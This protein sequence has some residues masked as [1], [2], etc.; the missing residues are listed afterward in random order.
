[1]VTVVVPVPVN[2]EVLA[3]SAGRLEGF[4]AT[5]TEYWNWATEAEE[6]WPVV[7]SQPTIRQVPWTPWLVRYVTVAWPCRLVV[8]P[9]ACGWPVAGL[10]SV[11][12]APIGVPWSSNTT[13]SSGTA[14]VG[15]VTVTTTPEMLVPSAGRPE[16][17]AETATMNGLGGGGW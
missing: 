1:M 4:A 5:A 14:P 17:V 15:P 2:A 9:P 11:P 8:Y 16:G 12:H 13:P 3:P 10:R 7:A 6:L